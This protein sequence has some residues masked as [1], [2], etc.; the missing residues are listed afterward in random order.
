[1]NNQIILGKTKKVS[2]IVK[3]VVEKNGIIYVLVKGNIK[4]VG[5]F[6]FFD[7]IKQGTTWTI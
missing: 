3:C 7:P 6:C 2:K 5:I 1:M 4:P